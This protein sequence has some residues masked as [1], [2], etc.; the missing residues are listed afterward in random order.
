MQAPIVT[1]AWLA[2]NNVIIL[3]ASQAHNIQ[4]AQP[5]Y[6]DQVIPNALH[7]DLKNTFSDKNAPFPNTMPNAKD[8]ESNV[9]KLGINSDD[10]VVIYDNLGIY[11]SPRVWW[12]FKAMGHENTF[13]LDGGLSAWIDAGNAT[14]KTHR[15]ATIKGNF[16]AR[17]NPH[18][19]KSYAD[20]LANISSQNCT[21]IDARST[22]RFDGTAPE[23]RAGMSSGHIP[24]SL[25]LPYSAV[26]N[27]E[28][29]KSPTEL[30]GIFHHLSLADKPIIFSCGSGLTACII[31]LAAELVNDC[32]KSVYDG[33][34]TE[35]AS[36]NGAPIH[37]TIA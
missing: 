10:V 9:Q 30:Q 11:H 17:L 20:V 21:L 7:F 22:E 37:K 33:S 13:V 18:A 4:S 27:G 28:F 36:T 24:H 25:N 31:L 35:W 1:A 29:M 15:S 16:I 14:T 34:W 19:I 23:P 32:P 8:F 26:L 2:K 5:K 3:D 12:M 6:A